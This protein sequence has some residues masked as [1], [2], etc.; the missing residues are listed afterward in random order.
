MRGV[1]IGQ[2]F[3]SRSLAQPVRRV[4]GTA[5]CARICP[6]IL[7]SGS[8]CCA[9]RAVNV[10]KS[11]PPGVRARRT[12]ARG[13]YSVATLVR[14]E[15]TGLDWNQ[16]GSCSTGCVKRLQG[17]TNIM[18]YRPPRPYRRGWPVISWRL[19]IRSN[20]E[21]HAGSPERSWSKAPGERCTLSPPRSRRSKSRRRGWRR[22]SSVPGR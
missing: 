15:P 22:G 1:K 3:L 19:L 8:R 9:S 5:C 13:E 17:V 4:F 14:A 21:S 2:L 10:G 6:S 12:D 20:A 16:S 11:R 18:C 7:T